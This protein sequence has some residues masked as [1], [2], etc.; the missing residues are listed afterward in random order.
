[1]K[2]IAVFIITIGIVAVIISMFRSKHFLKNL[3]STAFQGISSLLAV[4][5]IGLISGVTIALNWYTISAVSLL[6]IPSSIALLILDTLL[7]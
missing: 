4:N 6:G 7:R 1:M 3:V 2:T 5:V